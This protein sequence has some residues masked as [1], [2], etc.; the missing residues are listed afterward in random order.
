[1]WLSE[2]AAL[3]GS[4]PVRGGIP[5]VFPVRL[6]VLHICIKNKSNVLIWG[7]RSSAHP[8]NP[9]TPRPRSRNTASR[10]HPAG[11]SS[12][13]R[14]RRTRST[15]ILSSSTLGSTRQVSPRKRA[16]RGRSTLASYTASR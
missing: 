4:K 3:D 5:V 14:H 8:P 1:M 9:V 15:P 12:A 10:A 2:K 13:R 6:P 11:S 7:F 16:R